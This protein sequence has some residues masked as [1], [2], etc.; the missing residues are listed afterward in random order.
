L[1]VHH[2]KSPKSFITIPKDFSLAKVKWGIHK[3]K[4][5]IFHEFLTF[6]TEVQDEF[7]LI[8]FFISCSK[9]MHGLMTRPSRATCRGI[10]CE[11]LVDLKFR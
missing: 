3:N 2:L 5:K 8:Y 10:N 1:H 11:Q 9:P 4:S 6:Y 7:I